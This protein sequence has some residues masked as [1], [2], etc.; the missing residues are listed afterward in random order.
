MLAVEVQLGCF[1]DSSSRTHCREIVCLQR[2]HK[3]IVVVG[4]DP[5]LVSKIE[6]PKSCSQPGRYGDSYRHFC[7]FGGP[8]PANPPVKMPGIPRS[9]PFVSNVAERAIGYL[10][11]AVDVVVAT[12]ETSE[13]GGT[14]FR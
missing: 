12:L 1:V 7:H 6:L 13:D 9:E 5:G 2:S 4:C 8:E 11:L 3:K 10:G 14:L